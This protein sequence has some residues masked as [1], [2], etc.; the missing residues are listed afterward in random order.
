MKQIKLTQGKVTQVDDEDYVYLSWFKWY[1][2][3]DK[4][5]FYACRISRSEG[6]QTTVRMHRVIMNTP[7]GIQVDHIDRNGLNNCKSNLR[8]STASVNNQNKKT[9]AKSGYKGVTYYPNRTRCFASRCRINNKRL[10]LGYFET[11]EEAA[12][13]YDTKVLELYGNNAGL[14]F[15]Q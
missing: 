2:K 9:W 1:A 13:A 10:H 3:K 7:I 8:N 5:V 4:D 12:R 6:K 14:N 11:A 15:K